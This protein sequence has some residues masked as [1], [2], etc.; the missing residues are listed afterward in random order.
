MNCLSWNPATHCFPTS[1][2][3]PQPQNTGEFFRE[4]F[5]DPQVMAR[6]GIP[7]VLNQSFRGEPSSLSLTPSFH[8]ETP[9]LI[10]GHIPSTRRHLSS[11]RRHT[12]GW[13]GK[14]NSEVSLVRPLGDWSAITSSNPV[15]FTIRDDMLF[16]HVFLFCASQQTQSSMAEKQYFI[17]S[18]WWF[19]VRSMSVSFSVSS[20]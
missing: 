2:T 19:S 14:I 5:S 15:C 13:V 11:T 4:T 7:S 8:E 12:R 16:I 1:T 6:L 17:P 10:W 20:S 18:S 9:V 3:P